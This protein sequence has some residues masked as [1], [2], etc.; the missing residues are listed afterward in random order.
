MNLLNVKKTIVALVVLAVMV[1][2]SGCAKSVPIK[3]DVNAAPTDATVS[4]KGK[5]VGKTPLTIDVGDLSELTKITAQKSESEVIEV[6]IRIIST[7]KAE[8][9]FR[10][11]TEASP[12]V[13]ALGL[14]KVL[15]FDYSENATF[16]TDKYDLKP[17]LYPLLL[18]QADIL[19]KYFSSLPVYVCGH[20]DEVGSEEYNLTLSL[21]RA[22]AVADFL[23]ANKIVKSRL[24]VQGFGERYPIAVDQGREG[25]ARN[26]RTEI[27]LPQ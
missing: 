15:I 19:N 22:Q 24:K 4:F 6:R 21:K 3:T 7:D 9:F 13:K 27:L 16:D 1:M 2:M 8:V 11:G 23:S 10:F 20:T 17:V 18:K 12:L 14:N 5:E 25:H 26:R